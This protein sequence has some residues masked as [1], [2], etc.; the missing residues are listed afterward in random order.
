MHL[1][2]GGFT[3]VAEIR[4]GKSSYVLDQRGDQHGL[5]SRQHGLADSNL[6]AALILRADGTRAVRAIRLVGERLVDVTVL[7]AIETA[8]LAHEH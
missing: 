8:I 5:I 7:I 2:S 4:H 1:L 6:L 3:P